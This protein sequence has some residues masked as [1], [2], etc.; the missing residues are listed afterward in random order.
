LGRW[1]KT[2]LQLHYYKVQDIVDFIPVGNGDQAVGN[3]PRAQQAGFQSTSTINFDPLGWT[4]AKLNATFAGE[5]TSVRDPLTGKNRPISGT[6]DRWGNLQLRHDVPHTQLAWSAY[7]QYRHYVSN[8][9]LSEID[10]TLDIPWMAGFYIEDKNVLG[11]TM[12]LSVD[13]VFNGRH[14]EYRTVWDG[15][16]DRTPVAFIERH[17][18]LVGPIFSFSVKGTF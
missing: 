8:Y 17:N 16:R 13:N 5:W 11:T 18:E 14:L 10:Q 9:Y 3:L 4:G 12:R 15:Y 1:G 6:K 2:S 7:V